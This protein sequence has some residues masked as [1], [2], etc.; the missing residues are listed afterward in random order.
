[1]TKKRRWLKGLIV[2][3]LLMGNMTAFPLSNA[4]A[5]QTTQLEVG[6]MKHDQSQV[7]QGEEIPEEADLEIPIL[8]LS[9]LPHNKYFSRMTGRNHIQLSGNVRGMN[10]GDE[11]TINAQVDSNEAFVID[12]LKAN[13]SKQKFKTHKVEMDE[14]LEDGEHILRVWAM[15]QEGRESTVAEIEFIV[16]TQKPTEPTIK[17]VEELESDVGVEKLL[18]IQYPEDAVEKYYQIDDGAW[19]KYDGN[20]LVELGDSAE[21]LSKTVKARAVDI[22]GNESENQ[23]VILLARKAAPVLTV[24]PTLVEK[25]GNVTL[26]WTGTFLSYQVR[27]GTEYDNANLVKKYVSNTSYTFN[28]INV[29]PNT[30]LYCRVVGISDEGEVDSLVKTFTV[31][32]PSDT[33]PPTAPTLTASNIGDTNVT[34]SWT[35]SSDNVGVIGY[36][37]YR[38]DS[39]YTSVASSQRSLNITTLGSAKT[40]YFQVKA[41]D[42]AGNT[43]ASNQ[44]RVTT[45]GTDTLPPSAPVLTI[46]GVTST[47]AVLTWTESTDNVGVVGYLVNQGTTNQILLATVSPDVRTYTVTGLQPDTYYYFNVKAI[48]AA[49]NTRTSGA[50]LARTLADTQAPTA[51]VLSSPSK[52]DTTVTLSWTASTDNVGVTGYDVYVNGVYNSTTANRTIVIPQLLPNTS[53]SFIVKAKDA[54]GNVASSNTITVKTNLSLQLDKYKVV[55]APSNDGAVTDTLLV[56]LPGGTFTTDVASG[57]RVNNLPVGLVINVTRA[58]DTQLTVSFTGKAINHANLNDVTNASVTVLQSK[59]TGATSD[60]TSGLV[61]FDFM[62]PTATLNLST[63]IIHESQVNDGSINE[64]MV[65]TVENGVLAAD[66]SAGVS[67]TNLPAGLTLVVTRDSDTQF[68]IAFNGKAIS[69]TN[70]NDVANAFITVEKSK[71]NGATANIISGMFSFD[72]TDQN[73]VGTYVYEYDNQN[74]LISIT[75]NGAILY[76]FTYDANGNLKSKVKH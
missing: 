4:K 2:A 53:Y 69:H 38:D 39:L 33:Q 47:S 66:L 7:E 63:N 76:E 28:T 55:E 17:E 44:V 72:F 10:K 29:A 23:A 32:G 25:G 65:V 20:I 41:K 45:T 57:V 71:I 34:L 40:Y 74:R 48:D 51:P 15:D 8:K 50:T 70:Q 64:K 26:S 5:N 24:T 68:T 75:K 9:D 56:T 22:A 14:T 61:T 54:A 46:S 58:S 42:A 18:D 11:L 19:E 1:M 30:T 52:T 6:V 36:D 73:P 31:K 59:I 62:D 16:D 60:V 12:K 3:G 67:I 37:I 21:N 35:A 27:I 49:G 13:G 43:S